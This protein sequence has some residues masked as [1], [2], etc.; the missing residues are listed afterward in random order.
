M[1]E[2]KK[3]FSVFLCAAMMFTTLCFFPLGIIDTEAQAAVVNT[4]NE[5]A[6][7][8]PETIYLY[9]DVT[10]W[11][12]DV[13]TPFQYYV[14]NTVDTEN[15]YSAPVAEANLDSTGKIYFAAEEG[16][17]ELTLSVKFLDLLGNYLSEADFGTVNFT[18]ED[19][20][21]YHLITVTDGVSPSLEASVSGCYIEWCLT[22]KNALGEKKAAFNYSY[23]YKPYVVPYGAATRLYNSYGDV[24]VYGQHITWVSGVHSADNTATQTNTLYPYYMP[25]SDVSMSTDNNTDGSYSFSPFLSKDNKAYVAGEEISGAAPVRKGGYNA[26]FAGTNGTTAYFWANQTGAEFTQSYRVREFFRTYSYYDT[27]PVAF[28]YYSQAPLS[29]QYA[30]VQVTPGRLGTITVDVSRYGNLKDVPNLA[31]GMMTTDTDVEDAVTTNVSQADA[32]WYIG[33]GTGKAHLATGSYTSVSDLNNASNAVYVKFASEEDITAPLTNGILY[34][35]AWNKEL[36]SGTGVKTYTV[37]SYYEAQDRDGDRQ[38]AS[39]AVSL[40]V[41]QVDKTVLR[42]AVD[43]A[44]SN[45][46]VLGVKENWNSYYYDVN[47]ID[48]DTGT[49][50]WRRFQAAYINACGALGNVDVALPVTYDE[51]AAEL[52]R[53][54]DALLSGKGLRVY[55]DVNHDDIGVNLW[56]N[57]A[58]NGYTW[59]SDNET[60]VINGVISSSVVYGTTPFTPDGD[61]YIISVQQMSGT[62]DKNGCTVLDAVSAA[63]ANVSPRMNFDFSG[64]TQRVFNF[65]DNF[66]NVDGLKF[67]TWYNDSSR[68]PG[69][70]DNFA[71]RIKIEKGN[72][73]TEYSPVGKVTGAAYGTLPTPE[74]EGYLFGGWCTDE[75]LTTVVDEN[76][77]VSA[78][79]LYAKWE[80]AQ[81]NVVF[82]KN[83]ADGGEMPEQTMIYDE[84]ASLNVNKYTRTGYVFA[85]WTDEKG[86][87]YADGAEV[88]NLTSEH[89]GKYTLTAQWTPNQYSVAFDG[90]TGI[91]GLGMANAQYDTPFN[92]PANYFIKT[93]YTFSGWS[94][95]PDGEVLFTDGQEVSNLTSDVNGSVTLYAIWKANTFT[96]KLDANGGEGDMADASVVY[97]SGAALPECTFTRAGYTF[98]GWSLDAA[99]TELLT[100]AQYDNLMTEE[101]DEVTVYAIWSEN[102]YTLHLDKNG[103]SGTTVPATQYKYEA[104]VTLPANVY[105]MKGYV[106]AGWSLTKGGEIVYLNGATV[107]HICPDKNGSI[108]LYAV[109]EPVKYTVKFN[110]NSGEGQVDDAVMTYDSYK[111]LPSAETLTKL[112]YHFIGWA[113]TP[114]GGVA[115]S[116]GQS[117]RNLSDTNGAV[118]TFYAVWEINT[119]N[120]T[121]KYYNNVGTYVTVTVSVPHGGNVQ[122]PGDFSLYPYYSPSAHYIFAG[123]SQ[124]LENI[125]S[126][127]SINGRYQTTEAHDMASTS[128]DSTCAVAGYDRY[129]C[130]RCSY[131]YTNPRPLLDH[132][133]DEGSITVDPGCTSN[134][135]KVYTCVECGATK[136]EAVSPLGHSF[137]D[138]PYNAPTCDKEGNIA[139]KHCERCT[140]C[141]AS[142]ALTNAPD[143]EALTDEQVK[144]EKLP[145]T[146]GAAAD[147]TN[148][149]VCTVCGEI[150][151][152]KLGHTESVEYITTVA[153]CTKEGSYVKKVTCSVCGDV[154]SEETF[155]GTVPHTYESETFAPTCTEDGYIRYTC[156]VCGDTY[157]EADKPETGH[158]E[159]EWKVTTAPDCLNPGVETNYCAVCLA[160]WK[161]REVEAEGHDSGAWHVIVE[162]DCEGWGTESLDCT[163]CGVSLATKG[164][165]PKGHGEVKYEVTVEPGCESAGRNSRIC[166]DCGKELSFTVIPEKGHIADGAATCE[167]DSVC[168]G[169]GIILTPKFG[170]D[171]DDG[172]I[173]KEPT[174]TETGIK[175]QTCKNDPSHKNEI[176]LPVRIVIVVPE[177]TDFD[178]PESGYIGNVHHI[179]TVEEGMEYTVSCPENSAVI[180]DENGNLTAIADGE[181]EITVTT[182]DG[183]FT[184]TFT[185]TVRTLKTVRFDVRGEITELRTYVGETVTPP[186]VDSYVDGNFTYRFKNWTVDGAVAESFA[187]TGDMTFVAV[188]TSS[189]DYVQ[190]DR[191]SKIFLELINGDEADEGKLKLYK[192]EIEA[193]KAQIDEFALDR[194][195]R[196]AS[197]QKAIDAAANSISALISKIYPENQGRL[198]ITT[199]GPVGLGSV[200]SF[201]AFLSPINSIVSDGIW[202]SSDDSIGFF[203]GDKFHAVKQGTVTVTVSAGSRSASKE[204]TVIGGT[205]ARVIMFDSL[206]YNANYIVEGSY[207]IK[208]T[209]NMFW[210]PDAPVHFRVIDDGT[211]EEYYVYINDVRVT[212]AADGTYTI[213]GGTG[214]AHVRIEGVV[215]NEEGGKISFWQMIL[216]FF[217]KIGD[218]FR[219]LF[220]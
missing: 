209:T 220:A 211:F 142:S 87:T 122:L 139:H 111:A 89:Q 167:K 215:K 48:P 7:Y 83:G 165:E 71:V 13:R 30:L 200:T 74:R 81:Y 124:S 181:A 150:L 75:T 98:I 12:S 191:L 26:V 179:I 64:T 197:E 21:E 11:T 51:Y 78:R 17:S 24:R 4:G 186:Q 212:P 169:C 118:L 153:T 121:L 214:D 82:D 35:G 42:A 128:K 33:D 105:T 196:D 106:L 72:K 69:N 14:N 203:I 27:Y 88:L 31:V 113:T 157:D 164:I 123:W 206:V 208:E 56:I 125:T 86:N 132:T 198:F 46:A 155:F 32:Q 144:I 18:T 70:Y 1:R 141:F 93:G 184:K 65:T 112:G 22:Y 172:I 60:A 55:F 5:T 15:I 173:T 47:Y 109:W 151:K 59:N 147:C 168:T 130:N 92:L 183:K 100:A 204:I 34:A 54:L 23:I 127:V 102:S 101:G 28:D 213:D 99:G 193:A 217:K 76:S 37:K 174:E 177:E 166:L 185:I 63:N 44:V 114:T 104:S 9:P 163:K 205:A 68:I 103:G 40:N 210:A 19:K 25:L 95:S 39:A 97:D 2:L 94:T 201:T 36:T 66:T 10:S 145:H 91:G 73:T 176:I 115:Y 120:V 140:K 154:L 126:D 195:V 207:V 84:K 158:T 119:Y 199:E 182:A 62:F 136:S 85:G 96:V 156:T 180:M 20:G 38:A 41:N 50:A 43:R 148:D 107:K 160:G 57:P 6:F 67:W 16:V 8:V 146:A 131:S 137:K 80:K 152:E 202:T 49:S 53:S 218:F 189:C 159:G 110:A 162:P 134:G 77:A 178:A 175:T 58:Q 161:T 138:F 79:I 170:H 129:C 116:D 117:V 52:N 219:S 188:F 45:F 108:T 192:T 3:A 194:D 135:T 149:Q 171:W 216:D 143:S 190:F 61:S 133:Y 29:S 187:V 90:N